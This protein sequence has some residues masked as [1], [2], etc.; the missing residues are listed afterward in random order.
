MKLRLD[1]DARTADLKR[2]MSPSGVWIISQA[3]WSKE[4]P[5]GDRFAR[6]IR[7]DDNDWTLY[8]FSNA[9]GEILYWLSERRLV[10]IEPDAQGQPARFH[11]FVLPNEKVNSG[12]YPSAKPLTTVE[13]H[14]NTSAVKAALGSAYPD[15]RQ[16]SSL[17]ELETIKG[18]TDGFILGTPD[19]YGY[20]GVRFW[21]NAKTGNATLWSKCGPTH[22]SP[23]GAYFWSRTSKEISKV[24]PY[25][26]PADYDPT[27]PEP[28]FGLSVAAYRN[29]SH[30]IPLV[31][32]KDRANGADWLPPANPNKR[33]KR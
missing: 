12:G 10:G 22:P 29:P 26:D 27:L 20:H 11:F 9:P 25:P 24:R 8:G 28:G 6:L 30:L 16:A 5:K 13:L 2:D 21:I 14:L 31:S 33:L 1:L 19:E 23:N 17:T 32:G 4:N 7:I 3:S 18:R 15:Y